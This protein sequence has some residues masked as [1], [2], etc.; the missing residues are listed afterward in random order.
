MAIKVFTDTNIILDLFDHQRPHAQASKQL[1]KM[2]EDEK[3]MACI[4]E[5][6]L[7]TIDYILRKS[8]S[9]TKRMAV[10]NDL[11]AY[12]DILP[13][14]DAVCRKAIQQNFPDLE[15]AVLY[16]LA[17]ENEVDYFITNDNTALKK[18]A[19][20]QIPVITAVEFLKRVAE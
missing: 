11:M 6:V 10:Y 2:V 18:L 12:V 3:V 15:D 9:K 8:L 17:L 14:T 13:C 19:L 20:Q 16:Q 7:T 1:W 5:S 4:S